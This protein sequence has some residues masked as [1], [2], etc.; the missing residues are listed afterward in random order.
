MGRTVC[1]GGGW[2]RSGL[3]KIPHAV[4]VN[5]GKSTGHHPILLDP[6]AMAVAGVQGLTLL[7]EPARELA[8]PVS[9]PGLPDRDGLAIREDKIDQLE[10]G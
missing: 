2:W 10:R 8:G 3:R 5:P 6:L 9:L 1:K 7:R 4:F